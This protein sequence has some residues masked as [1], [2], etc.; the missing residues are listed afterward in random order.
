MIML[1]VQY[2]ALVDCRSR[3]QYLSEMVV[4]SD[5]GTIILKLFIGMVRKVLVKLILNKKI[6][7]S[8]I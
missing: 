7:F 5:I 8:D 1:V 3:I 4:C 2:S 6:N